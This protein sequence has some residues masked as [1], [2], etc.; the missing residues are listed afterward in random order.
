MPTAEGAE[1]LWQAIGLREPSPDDCVK[2]IHEI[3]RNRRRAPVPD[4]ETILLE[5]FRVLAERHAKGETVKDLRQ[6]AQMRLW[7]SQGWVSQ[8]PVYATGDSSLAEGIG[9]RLPLWK[10]GGDL[11]QFRNLLGPL[12]VE[13]ICVVD[14]E[15]IDSDLAREDLALTVL[16]R[17]AIEHLQ[18]DLSRNDAKIA[19]GIKI[20]WD[21]L[22]RFSVYIHPSLRF[23]LP[24]LRKGATEVYVLH[25]SRPMPAAVDEAKREGLP[26]RLEHADGQGEAHLIALACGDGG[27]KG[28]SRE[29]QL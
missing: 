12:K 11:E 20:P 5:T 2:V 7:T 18:E 3:T 21:R 6:W 27:G 16:F 8:R 28:D 9:D 29:H 10:P 25:T 19:Q 26:R 14:A 23:R 22:L 13:E 15:V 4:E 17:S 24:V 1:R